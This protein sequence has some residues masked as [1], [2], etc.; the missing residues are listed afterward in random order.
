MS[1]PR[2]VADL[3]AAT[4]VHASA[5]VSISGFQIDQMHLCAGDASK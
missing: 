2:F 1:L 4:A 3:K 5:V